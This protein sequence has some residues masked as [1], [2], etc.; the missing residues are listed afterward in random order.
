MNHKITNDDD[1][2]DLCCFYIVVAA[3]DDDGDYDDEICQ[4]FTCI[5]WEEINYNIYDCSNV[6]S[7]VLVS[8]NIW[9]RMSRFLHWNVYAWR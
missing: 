3:A 8:P 2:D 6:H 1:D 9:R 7:F 4:Q 5:K